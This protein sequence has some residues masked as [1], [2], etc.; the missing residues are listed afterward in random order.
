MKPFLEAN[1]DPVTVLVAREMEAISD[2]DI[3]AWAGRHAAPLSYADD[4]D[5]LQLVRCNPR[6]ALALGKAHGHLTSLV[7][8]RFPDFNHSSAVATEIARQLFLRRIRAYL[9]SDLKPFQIC[10]MVHRI[11]AK[12]GYLQW[13]GGLYDACDWMDERTTRDQASD[14]R[15]AVEH[16]LRNGTETRPSEAVE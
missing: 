1:E 2:A 14:L 9:H 8:R 3:V 15:A 5:Y 4:T 12:Y 10:R 6:N 7:A 13:L 11:E 16:I